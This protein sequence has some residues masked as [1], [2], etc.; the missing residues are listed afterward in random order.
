MLP[1][2]GGKRKGGTQPPQ[3]DAS[4]GER[5]QNHDAS[6]TSK[7]KEKKRSTQPAVPADEQPTSLVPL[8]PAI[9]KSEGKRNG[10]H[11]IGDPAASTSTMPPE[12]GGSFAAS[13][14]SALGDILQHVNDDGNADQPCVHAPEGM[15][16]IPAMKDDDRGPAALSP[17]PAFAARLDTADYDFSMHTARST[18]GGRLRLKDMEPNSV[19]YVYERHRRR[20]Q[21]TTP[22]NSLPTSAQR[23]RADTSM[24]SARR[25]TQADS[26]FSSIIDHLGVLDDETRQSVR[27][28]LLP[29]KVVEDGF[30]EQFAQ[31]LKH[32]VSRNRPECLQ[33]AQYHRDQLLLQMFNRGTELVER[34]EQRVHEIELAHRNLQASKKE[35]QLQQARQT[36]LQVIR[37]V[38]FATG[39]MDHLQSLKSIETLRRTMLP[40]VIRKKNI[41]RKRWD[42][43]DIT[44]MRLD[45]N[46]VPTPGMI[47]QMQGQFFEGWS[48]HEL[49]A[50]ISSAKP[51]SYL[52]REYI[53][54]EGDYDRVMYL[55]TKGKVEVQIRDKKLKEKRRC[56]E[57]SAARFP[58]QAPAY[59][60]EFALLCKEPR[61]ASIQCM[62]DVD[63]WVVS[64]KSFD[65]VVKLLS[66]AIASKQ[67]EAT[68]LRRKANLRK[69]FS[70]RPET[71][72]R[73]KYFA[74]WDLSVLR[75]MSAALE[76]LVLRANKR[77]YREGDYEP[78]LYFIADGTLRLTKP[79]EPSEPPAEFGPGDV[80]G[81]FE[82]FFL[83]ER[84]SQ[85]A[86]CVTNCDLWR[87]SRQ[88]LLDLGMSD[89]AALV[90]SKLVVQESKTADM[91][92]LPKA[93]AYV[94]QDPYLSFVL[95][96]SQMQLLWQLGVPRVVGA[97]E[98]LSIE[99]DD[100][101]YIY[102]VV[103]GS[104]HV[105]HLDKDL[106]KYDDKLVVSPILGGVHTGTHYSNANLKAMFPSVTFCE[107]PK[108]GS[109][110]MA[111]P[112]KSF[113]KPSMHQGSG[114]GAASNNNA[115]LRQLTKQMSSSINM[116]PSLMIA[117]K[118]GCIGVVLGAYEFAARQSRWNATYRCASMCEVFVVE[119][120]AFEAQLPQ[121]LVQL[122]RSATAQTRLLIEAFL[123]RSAA[124]L[125]SLPSAQRIAGMYLALKAQEKQKDKSAGQ[126][127]KARNAAQRSVL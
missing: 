64:A 43:R 5:K 77:L 39:V 41:L 73:N 38:Q 54:F 78:A 31:R 51:L 70:L 4:I 116:D 108:V 34:H 3:R 32:V 11:N 71:I 79:S 101:K 91:Y 123:S 52:E 126:Q 1:V 62:T 120:E 76:P 98:H 97:G 49:N 44:E 28:K 100:A 122:H 53:M 37:A 55:I 113:R 33:R 127:E 83:Q 68:D 29:K 111:K 104:L 109:S 59:V 17:A 118:E 58:L 46:P 25:R 9:H 57:F 72:R 119:R 112:S 47:R 74:E 102:F 61:S 19:E 56:A 88:Q 80:V 110:S 26:V 125:M 89:P 12:G 75:D 45:E 124:S 15:S 23:Q 36:W 21:T 121:P 24:D 50:L 65:A 95:P 18:A 2:I 66:P 22:T 114:G 13:R 90:K 115:S 35:A 92:K 6:T 96:S 81:A 105:S 14:T 106:K 16:P 86:V 42:R 117:Q 93:P 82:T 99:G 48:D 85:T 30:D 84:R 94:T 20:C 60:G 103:L 40:L 107:I 8:L 10:Q 63:M 69:Y 27:E 67:Q 7:T 87:L